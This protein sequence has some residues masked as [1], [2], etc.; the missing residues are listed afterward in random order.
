MHIRLFLRG[1]GGS[2]G[3]TKPCTDTEEPISLANP[4]VYGTFTP[5]GAKVEFLSHLHCTWIFTCIPPAN[6][7]N[8]EC[9]VLRGR[10]THL[11]FDMV[12]TTS[13]SKSTVSPSKPSPNDNHP[14]L[15]EGVIWFTAE[16]E[17][18]Q[19]QIP[20]KVEVFPSR[21]TPHAETKQSV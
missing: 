5:D 9:Y 1:L 14:L 10:H 19:Y 18:E 20:G 6:K 3:R 17:T 16:C 2:S 4:V 8:A 13:L 12:V 15:W 11:T 7:G 21:S